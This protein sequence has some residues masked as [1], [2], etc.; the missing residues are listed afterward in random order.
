LTESDSS[1]NSTDD[2]EGLNDEEEVEEEKEKE[3]K[4]TFIEKL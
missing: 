3:S 4:Q 1:L 2:Y